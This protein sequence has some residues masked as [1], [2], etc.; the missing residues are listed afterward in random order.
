MGSNETLVHSRIWPSLQ[1]LPI[2][3]QTR[4]VVLAANVPPS[5]HQV[6]GEPRREA[7]KKL[8]SAQAELLNACLSLLKFN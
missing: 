7:M 3:S 6:G 2:S 1:G 4:L 5:H 8:L